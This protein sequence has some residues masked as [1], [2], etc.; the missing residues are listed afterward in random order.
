MIPRLTAPMARSRTMAKTSSGLPAFAT[1]RPSE[2][3]GSGPS[4]A[5]CTSAR[6][7][8]RS[9]MTWIVARMPNPAT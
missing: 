8:V 6:E 2:K 1:P 9:T 3:A 7:N 4:A 5:T